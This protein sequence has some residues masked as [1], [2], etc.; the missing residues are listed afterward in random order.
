MAR[1]PIEMKVDQACGFD[2]AS[3][4]PPIKLECPHCKAEKMAR[5]LEHD[6]PNT[7]IV[8]SAC[9]KC[10]KE[11]DQPDVT[12]YDKLGRML[13]LDGNCH[14]NETIEEDHGRGIIWQDRRGT[15][16]L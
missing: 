4:P 12:Y 2:P 5:R 8:C 7:W 1:S 3:V 6:P 11:G 15:V 9:P 10:I 13:D 14:R 16:V